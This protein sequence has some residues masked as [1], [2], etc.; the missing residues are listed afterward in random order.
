MATAVD[1]AQLLNHPADDNTPSQ[2]ITTRKKK[3]Q[4]III[5]PFASYLNQA[6]AEE[7]IR[8]LASSLNTIYLC[9]VQTNTEG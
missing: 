3:S 1:E 8:E 2:L 5:L 7:L 6:A 9:W 4:C